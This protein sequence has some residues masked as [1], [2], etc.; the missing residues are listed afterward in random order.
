MKKL[1]Y[2]L[3]FIVPMAVKAQS[4]YYPPVGNS[5][6]ETVSPDS[7]G[8]CTK[9]LDT[10]YKYLDAKNSK[11]FIILKGGK[12]AVE[13]YFDA[14]TL[15]SNWYWASAG[16]TITAFLM[17]IAQQDGKLKITDS[18][19]KY[20]GKGWTQTPANKEKLITIWHQ[21][22]MT[23][24][25]D[26]AIPPTIQE[27]DPDNCMKPECLLYKADAGTRWAYH[28]A[29]YR[30]LQDIIDSATGISMNQ[31][32]AQK[33]K[34]TIGLDGLWFDYIFYSKPRVMARF[35]SLIINKG[36]WG[37][38]QLMTD[39]SYFNAMVSTS[40]SINPSYGYL[41]WLNGKAKYKVPTVQFDING[42]LIPNAPADL[43]AG[44]GKND[45]KLYIIPSMDMVI[46]RMGD[47]S[48]QPTLAL[49]SFDN[50]LWGLLK[51]V[52]CPNGPPVGVTENTSPSPFAVYPNPAGN[53]LYTNATQTVQTE[54]FDMTG[55]KLMATTLSPSEGIDISGLKVGSYIIKINDGQTTSRS[56]FVKE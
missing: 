31:Y 46:V 44:L 28:N 54:I 30:L 23:N 18:T 56:I 34:N 15:D 55:R 1:V 8:W 42:P 48:G 4:Y 10:V 37:N 14:F 16:K 43:Y 50:E 41:W 9:K 36:K 35:G 12:I 45:Q 49:S 5:Q 47:A 7:L 29:P 2:L 11:A 38:N 13:K 22:T 19:S 20:L 53:W 3:F 33:L 17:G 25:L 51:D 32:T 27:P 26:D 6:W 39:S 21:L 24:G 52:F 40:Q